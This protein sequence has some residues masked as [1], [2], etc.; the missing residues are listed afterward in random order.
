VSPS[1]WARLVAST[2]AAIARSTGHRYAFSTRWWLD[3]IS[4]TTPSTPQSAA[5]CTSSTMHRE[6]A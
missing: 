1:S 3:G 4:M 6:N 2:D 5:R